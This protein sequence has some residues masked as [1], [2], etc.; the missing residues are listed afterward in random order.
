MTLP[1]A[2]LCSYSRKPLDRCRR[3]LH[4]TSNA[5]RASSGVVSIGNENSCT[6]EVRLRTLVG[7]N[8]EGK[9]RGGPII[10]SGEKVVLCSREMWC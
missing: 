2:R 6:R 5:L 10:S 9:K 4:A 3:K 1:M 8:I 7:I